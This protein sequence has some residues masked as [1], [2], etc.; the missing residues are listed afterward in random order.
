MFV[1]GGISGH[2][3]LMNRNLDISLLRTFVTTIDEGSVTAAATKLH[4]TQSAVSQ[5]LHRLEA[6][7]RVQL[8][9]RDHLGSRATSSGLRLLG[10]ARDILAAND[11]VLAEMTGAISGR[12]RI[13]VPED[14][15]A[16]VLHPVLRRFSRTHPAVDISLLAA[17]S[18][19]V[20]KALESGHADLV[21]VE[22]P[23]KT[24]P[25]FEQL[26]SDQLVW[27]GAP[28]GSA[29]KE[30]TLPLSFAAQNCAFRPVVEAALQAGDRIWRTALDGE[31][32]EATLAAIR[33]DLAVGVWLHS[34]VPAGLQ[35]L[36]DTSLPILPPFSIGLGLPS[37][38][39]P[40]PPAL[41][42]A[43]ALRSYERERLAAQ[44]S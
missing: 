37:K 14:L 6:L 38:H 13:G 19:D 16:G 43:D 41:A 10:R 22:E 21:L 27:I 35:V 40:T 31:G 15:I 24:S 28:G 12:L 5:Q 2:N 39:A 34:I 18:I 29:Y 42:L 3:G 25:K 32:T 17:P 8:L 36:S 7:L 11:L 44:R 9:I 4:L 23:D 33:A 30:G 26:W 1:K 20:I